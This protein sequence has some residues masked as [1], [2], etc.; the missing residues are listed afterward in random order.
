VIRPERPSLF[1]SLVPEDG[2]TDV[3]QHVRQAALF[4]QATV[5]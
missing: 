4:D 5:R 1:T 2:G 3:Y